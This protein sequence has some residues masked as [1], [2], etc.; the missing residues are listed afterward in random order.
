ME[1]K[2]PDN[3][4]NLVWDQLDN[5][6]KSSLISSIN[7]NN[8]LPNKL[9][10]NINNKYMITDKDI[11]KRKLH[12]N[13]SIN[14]LLDELLEY[15]WDINSN[16]NFNKWNLEDLSK[17]TKYE[18]ILIDYKN[19][20]EY[21]ITNMNNLEF[22]YKDYLNGFNDYSFQL[23]RVWPLC[24]NYSY[25]LGYELS[26]YKNDIKYTKNNT[27]PLYNYYKSD[28]KYNTDGLYNAELDSKWKLLSEN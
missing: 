27:K 6:G 22:N 24:K 26:N 7:R 19:T 9:C 25:D 21:N 28:Y 17:I 8:Y 12:Y 15:I 20:P 11:W 13:K 2:K 10:D 18:N 1:L 14:K 16:N 23:G 5:I 3:I 4:Q